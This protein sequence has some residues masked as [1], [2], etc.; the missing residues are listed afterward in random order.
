M[1]I[2]FH[3]ITLMLCDKLACAMNSYKY[4]FKIQMHE[5]FIGANSL[6]QLILFPLRMTF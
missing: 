6:N 1:C 5:E 2:L 3:I 4:H